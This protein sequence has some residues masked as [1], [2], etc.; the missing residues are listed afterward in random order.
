MCINIANTRVFEG[1]GWSYEFPLAMNLMFPWD[2]YSTSPPM[3]TI[4]GISNIVICGMYIS[5][6]FRFDFLKSLH[7]HSPLIIKLSQN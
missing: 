7:P 4:V 5:L 6:C 1:Y 3:Y 2:Y